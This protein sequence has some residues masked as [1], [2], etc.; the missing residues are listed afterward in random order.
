MDI[1]IITGASSGLGREYV[2]AVLKRYPNLDKIW[3]IARREDRLLEVKK[4]NRQKIE[5]FPMDITKEE[6]IE[7]LE[8]Q[9]KLNNANVKLLINNAGFGKLGKFEEL[10]LQN[11]T[12]MIKLNCEAFTAII[13]AVLPFMGENSKIINTCSI[14]SFAP[15]TR[16][17]VYSSTKAYVMSLSLGLREEL[18][19]KKI[20]VLAVCPG[21][22]DT[23]FLPVANIGKADSKT[24]DRLPRVIPSVIAEKSLR[25]SDKNRSVY[26]NKFIYK[27][28]RLVTKILP[29]TIT[30]KFCGA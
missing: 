28:F 19:G 20:N 16:L 15:N 22:M 10:S 4:A 5:V 29:K 25:V 13:Y 9:L 2:F 23:E 3:I 14:A 8:E 26:T 30:M 6:S 11:N 17:A 21:P 18:K 24:F 27:L 7:K 1:A 12:G